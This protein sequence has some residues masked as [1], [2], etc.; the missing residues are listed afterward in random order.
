MRRSIAAPPGDAWYVYGLETLLEHCEFGWRPVKRCMSA[1][2]EPD[3]AA[4]IRP[5][6]APPQSSGSSSS[7]SADAAAETSLPPDFGGRPPPAEAE[8]L[9]DPGAQVLSLL[10]PVSITMALVV[11]LVHEM[12]AASQQIAGGFSDL[13]V[14]Q[15]SATDS[16]G[17][18]LGGVVLNALVVV[19]T[20]FLVTALVTPANIYALT[21]G[22]NFP[23]DV[24]T[25]PTAHA[26]RL[27]SQAVLLAM[28]LEMA[29]PTLLDAKVN[30]GLM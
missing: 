11:Y 21:H 9:G 19:L 3:A 22:A 25:P 14:Y 15:E 29:Q 23:L 8:D 6:M 4:E 30:L 17:T 16:A 12:S 28:L 5:L 26:V 1:E 10:K 24:E 2:A 27:A 7:E 18:I 20:L 13:M